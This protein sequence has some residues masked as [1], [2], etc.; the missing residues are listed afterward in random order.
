ML[1]GL[2]IDPESV[3]DDGALV[4][5]L[6]IASATLARARRQGKL[7][8]RRVG[9]R[10]LYLGR[11]ILDWLEATDSAPPSQEAAHV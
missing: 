5:A 6:G 8:F 10:T 7:R 2:K 1:A 9:N 3:Y 4:M 11:W